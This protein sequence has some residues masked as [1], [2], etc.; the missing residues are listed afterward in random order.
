MF[1]LTAEMATTTFEMIYMYGA[2]NLKPIYALKNHIFPR[3]MAETAM[4]PSNI[5]TAT[6]SA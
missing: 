3:L 2:K 5:Y 4:T 1:L 6:T